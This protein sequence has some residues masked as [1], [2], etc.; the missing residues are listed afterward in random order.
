MKILRI[1]QIKP[2]F[3]F[4]LRVTFDDGKTGVFDVAPYLECD[5]FH[6]LKKQAEFQRV[7]NGGYFVEWAC[8]ADLSA[9]T[10]AAHMF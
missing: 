9:D 2:E 4:R 3:G 10:L 6:P 7:R 8:G 5:A 1:K